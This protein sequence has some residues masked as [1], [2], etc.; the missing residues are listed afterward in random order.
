LTIKFFL[1]KKER[2]RRRA[3]TNVKETVGFLIGG[4]SLSLS[5]TRRKNKRK[6]GKKKKKKK[7]REVVTKRTQSRIS[8][9]PAVRELVWLSLSTQR[10]SSFLYRLLLAAV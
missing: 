4:L 8:H 3:R 7:T 6:L 1:I 9:M 5:P 10:S 2:E